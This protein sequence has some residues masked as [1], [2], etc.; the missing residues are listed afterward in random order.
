MGEVFLLSRS[1][2]QDYSDYSGICAGYQLLCVSLARDNNPPSG[3]RGPHLLCWLAEHF[4]VHCFALLCC[5]GR[6]CFWHRV[7]LLPRTRILYH[8]QVND[9][10]CRSIPLFFFF[11]SSMIMIVFHQG[12]YFAKQ[13]HHTSIPRH[14]RFFL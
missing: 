2:A 11:S 5:Q 4:A 12:T 3:A 10:C 14:K 8:S 6:S 9:S 13:F 1:L 7:P